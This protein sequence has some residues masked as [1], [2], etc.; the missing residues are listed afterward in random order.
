MLRLS[1]SP[2]HLTDRFTHSWA[3]FSHLCPATL[4]CGC[5]ILIKLERPKK[6]VWSDLRHPETA[7]KDKEA[8]PRTE[9]IRPA[10]RG[11]GHTPHLPLLRPQGAWL[12][13]TVAE[14][15]PPGPTT[16]RVFSQPELY[17][18][19]RVLR[20]FH[21]DKGHRPQTRFCAEIRDLCPDPFLWCPFNVNTVE[22]CL[23]QPPDYRWGA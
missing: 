3:N 23:W 21:P 18:G 5:A 4:R 6:L 12:V 7:K 8:H 14:D 13:A 1:L 15:F 17:A 16:V 22:C 2:Q 19:H 10:Q 9:A 11:E 20:G